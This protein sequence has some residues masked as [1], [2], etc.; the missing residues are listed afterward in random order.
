MS[1]HRRTPGADPVA[2][3]RALRRLAAV[4]HR[5]SPEGAGPAPSASTDLGEE[6]AVQGGWTPDQAVPDRLRG[7][8]WRLAPAH[9]AVMAV[10][11][12]AGLAW[13]ISSVLVSRP[14]PVP[15]RPTAG[16]TPGAAV[17]G[18]SVPPTAGSQT[19]GSPTA[20]SQT[21]AHV[22]V[23]VAGKV[24]R[25]GLIRT[26]AGSRVADVL[27]AAGGALPGVDLTT[28]NL[29][30]VVVDGEQIVVGV[31]LPSVG[32]GAVS[33]P[34]AEASGGRV[35]LNAATVEQLEQLP[36]VGPVLA[37]RIVDWRTE[38]GRFTSVDELQEVSGV[39]PKKFESLKD[40]VRV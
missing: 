16:L 39:G 30:R 2:R 33:S 36:G 4:P 37:Q 31:P 11:L 28:L 35:D 18:G 9:V 5:P 34:G 1:R 29:A 21:A 24:R 10:V 8:R 17:S 25:P 32:P 6:I 40:H 20:G 22:V 7:S 15:E 3:Q 26:S 38:H 12:V 13:V 23:H 27:A 19:D 14:A